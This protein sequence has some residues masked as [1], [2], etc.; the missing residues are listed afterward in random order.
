MVV[1]AMGDM[2]FPHTAPEKS[3]PKTGIKIEAFS[4]VVGNGRAN[5]LVVICT[6]I[7]TR[8]AI[9]PHADPVIN[10]VKIEIK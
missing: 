10:A 5:R 1:S 6:A 4:R 8:R 9:V 3:A 7:G 2:W